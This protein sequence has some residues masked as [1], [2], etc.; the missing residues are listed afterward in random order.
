[1]ICQSDKGKRIPMKITS[2]QFENGGWMPDSIAG[3]GEDMSPDILIDGLPEDTVSIAVTMDDLDHPIK[4]GFNHWVAWNIEPSCR[5]PGGI[6]KGGVLETPIHIEQG[7]GYGRHCYRGPKPPFNGNHRYTVT[8]YALDIKLK[9]GSNS[10]KKDLL[11]AIDSHILG[12]GE[13]TGRY[14]RRH[15]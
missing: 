7:I 5:I 3:Y 12:K 2:T 8:V 6:P 13:I 14:Q 10:R 4:P 1:M 9:L 15:S 11:S